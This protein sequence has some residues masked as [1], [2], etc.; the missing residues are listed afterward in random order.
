M[1]TMLKDLFGGGGPSLQQA[2]DF[3]N[4]FEQGPLDQGYTPQEAFQNYQQVAQ[5]A[6]PDVL[7]RAAQQTFGRMDPSQRQEFAQLLQQQTGGQ[8]A[9]GIAQDPRQLASMVT[10]VH[11]QQPGG[12]A[13]LFGGGGG[14]GGGLGGMMGNPLAKVAL[15]GIAAFA[16]KELMG[17]RGGQ[18][19]PKLSV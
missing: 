16:M 13:S 17:N 8:M 14:G 4:R 9:A 10:Q 1:D 6:P 5:A 19:S 7:E 15:G 3:V 11:Q 12:L 2:Q 18:Q